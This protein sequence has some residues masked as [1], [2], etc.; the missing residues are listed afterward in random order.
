MLQTKEQEPLLLTAAEINREIMRISPRTL[1]RAQ[2][3]GDIKA[4]LHGGK[5]RFERPS[6][7]A[8]ISGKRRRGRPRKEVAK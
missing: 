5:W 2:A 8:W 3:R 1:K 6:V 4:Y 7:L